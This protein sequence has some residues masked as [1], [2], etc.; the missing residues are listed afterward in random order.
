MPGIAMLRMEEPAQ[1]NPEKLETLCDR[2][3]ELEAEEAVA[4]ALG[5]IAHVVRN[6]PSIPDGMLREEIGALAIDAD[7]IGMST[8]ARVSR[9]VVRCM[10]RRD[11][12]AVAATLARLVR[13]GERSLHAVWE[14]ETLSG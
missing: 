3:G 12:I 4:D 10:A 6:L 11:A 8:L 5:R 1:F 13:V 7:L 9:D 14:L 2:L